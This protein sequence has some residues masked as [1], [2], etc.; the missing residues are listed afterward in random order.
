MGPGKDAG[1]LEE[2]WEGAVRI[3]LRHLPDRL[4]A[5]VSEVTRSAPVTSGS[6]N[7]CCLPAISS[8]EVTRSAAVTS[9]SN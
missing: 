1:Y 2:L 3:A 6:S 4:P 7:C 8:T 5:T 9:G